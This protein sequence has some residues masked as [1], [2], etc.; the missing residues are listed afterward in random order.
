ML[1]VRRGLIL[2]VVLFVL[3]L[4]GLFAAQFAFRV[5]ADLASTRA[6]HYRMQTRLAAE[7]GVEVVK[8]VLR[9]A[10]LDMGRWWHNPDEFHRIVVWAYDGDSTV[11]G[12]NEVFEEETMAYRFS[13]V[14]D[15]P[16]D[17]LRYVRYGITDESSKLNLNV[18]G[19]SQLLTLLNAVVGD[20]EE[21]DPQ[22]IVDAI[23]DWR[24]QD[25]EPRGKARDTEGEYYRSLDKPYR[26]KN[27]PFDTVEELLLV[28]G[29]TARIL[30]GEDFDRNGLLTANEDDGDELFPPDDRDGALNRGLYPFLTV[31]S[32]ESNVSN[33]NRA[34][35]DL[36]SS[37]VEVRDKLDR[38]FEDE[39][40]VVEFIA[41][42]TGVHFNYDDDS[43]DNNDENTPVMIRSP[44]SLLRARLLVP[45]SIGPMVHPSASNPLTLDHLPI[46]MDRTTV[47][48]ENR[49][50]GL[51][52]IITAPPLVLRTLPVLTDD[53][54]ATIVELRES[55][56]EEGRATT[57]WLVT[58]GILPLERYERLARYITSR[59]QQ[60]TIESLGY[61]DHVGTVTRLQVIVDTV[62]PIPQTLYY[63]DLS[64]LGALF[65]I[66]EE[67]QVRFRIE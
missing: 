10:R 43:W 66:R 64:R 27:G 52:N 65:P 31:H 47:R 59:G 53:E 22:A 35:I 54:I 37:S 46:L 7:A 16:T 3:L 21:I 55:L 63:R 24:D 48:S 34:R 12:T 39:P 42:V 50:A 5:N 6:V 32:Y 67:H 40:E 2:P 57:A 41:N 29:V 44:A 28:K 20:D 38:I 15:D 30:F 13:I 26:V 25:A 8:L 60:F 51:I 45:T 61:A 14:A 36:F 58:E 23:L 11:W 1:A 49:T 56:T 17:D 18:A 4:L 9:D 62:G 33:D 19:E